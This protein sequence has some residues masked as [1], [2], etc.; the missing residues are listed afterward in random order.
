MFLEAADHAQLFVLAVAVRR[1]A[2][3]VRGLPG[4]ARC[5][6]RRLRGLAGPLGLALGGCRGVL[7]P[8]RRLLDRARLLAR[9]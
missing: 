7:E 3:L 1:G 9:A 4:S 5:I 8:A 2:R 6:L